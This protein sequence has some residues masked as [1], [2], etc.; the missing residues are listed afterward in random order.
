[1]KKYD[2]QT[3]LALSQNARIELNTFSDQELGHNLLRQ[4]K[5]STRALTEQSVNRSRA[6]SSISHQTESPLSRLHGP[7]RVPKDPPRSSR[8]QIDAGF[9]RFLK[10]HTSPKHQRVTAGGRI[11]PMDPQ[12]PVP[13]LK[14]PVQKKQ[15]GDHEVE[16]LES[17]RW[18]EHESVPRNIPVGPMETSSN[19]SDISRNSAGPCG[20][21]PDIAR[22]SLTNGIFDQASQ[23]SGCPPIISWPAPGYTLPS[24]F[25]VAFN[26]Q[27]APLV[28]QYPQATYVPVLP[29]HAMYDVGSDIRPSVPDMYQSLNMQGNMSSMPTSL[30]PDLPVSTASSDFALCSNM[31]N[32]G[33]ISAFSQGQLSYETGYPN[34]APQVYPSV[35]RQF[36]ALKQS[37]YLSG[38]QQG[39]SHLKC[40]DEAKKQYE[41]LSAE[42]SRLDRYMAIHTWDID[43]QS[44]SMMVEQR[45]SLVRELDVVRMYRERLELIF[46]R[47][48]MNDS[49]GQQKVNTKIHAPPSSYLTTDYQGFPGSMSSSSSASCTSE[50]LP[51]YFA[52]SAFPI[53]C[54]ESET[55]IPVFP[56]Q[57]SGNPCSAGGVKNMSANGIIGNP[58][59]SQQ[60]N[61][62]GTS[63]CDK[64]RDK[65]IRASIPSD[66]SGSTGDE[67]A[68]S[69]ML[70][71]LDLQ[72]LYHKIEKATERGEP[73]GRLLKELSVVTTQLV[74]QNREEGRIP[75]PSTR[76]K[77]VFSSLPNSNPN[78]T[79]IATDGRQMEH[80]RHL[81]VPRA[82]PRESVESC[83]D[84]SSM[85]DNEANG[86]LSSSCVSTTDS[87]TT[88]H[89]RNKPLVSMDPLED[90]I[91]GN[92]ETIWGSPRAHSKYKT[93]PSKTHALDA[94]QNIRW[95]QE[96]LEDRQE[97]KPRNTIMLHQTHRIRR[98]NT[99]IQSIKMPMSSLNTQLLSRNRGLVFQ[100]TAALAVPQ[101]VNVQAYVPFFDGPGDD[102]RNE[103]SQRT[104]EN[105]GNQVQGTGFHSSVQETRPWYVP[106]QRPKPSRETLRAF[107]RQ[108]REE[109]RREILNSKNRNQSNGQ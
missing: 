1:M 34:F 83:G 47:P 106:K 76:G 77:P 58:N 11:V 70:S 68:S 44:K 84:M 94:P 6:V 16:A 101:N 93:V 99:D 49:S 24:V 90:L 45:K 28:D 104:M 109:E 105:G 4:N 86:K 81:W 26:N 73:V 62:M 102:A 67:Q 91:Y 75:H 33:S 19:R 22:L 40:L 29:D 15:S 66:E 27:Q 39:T 60:N 55:P 53:I 64:H 103:T 52:P 72:R 41:S 10:D 88:I 107:F 108:V 78:S 69:R 35:G 7:I 2:I 38:M 100:K 56:W 98:G 74:K 13:I 57:K 36:P 32:V 17:L 59:W 25:P 46:G 31:A 95:I 30:Q 85:S 37:Q 14:F 79:R 51:T 71:P 82:H 87:W 48:N 23:E 50:T 9:A 20:I 89:G 97:V 63:L 12:T 61:D 80:A 54:P 96:Q 42:L 3:L 5:T 65:K 18:I 43:S 92:P 21:L 8:A